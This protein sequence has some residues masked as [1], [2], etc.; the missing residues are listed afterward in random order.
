MTDAGDLSNPAPA[1]VEPTPPLSTSTPA[2]PGPAV[3]STPVDVELVPPPPN[4]SDWPAQATD[5]IVNLVDQV[6]AKTTGPA[7]TVA[8][9]LVFGLIVG[10]LGLMAAVLLLIFAVRLTTDVLELIWDGAGVWLTYLI[11]GVLF[12]LVGSYVFGKRHVRGLD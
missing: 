10:V 2:S 1:P 5:T 11:Y 7:I 3:G 9:G 4:T 8:R 6:R 12:T